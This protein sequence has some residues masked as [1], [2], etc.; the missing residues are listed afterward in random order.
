MY[1]L[2]KAVIDYSARSISYMKVF[3]YRDGYSWT[4][5]ASARL[6]RLIERVCSSATTR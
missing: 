5:R 1:L 6:T 4:L 3:G 2:T